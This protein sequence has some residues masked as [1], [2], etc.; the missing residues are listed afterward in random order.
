MPSG[1]CLVGVL[2][3]IELWHV[4]AWPAVCGWDGKDSCRVYLRG[5]GGTGGGRK[6]YAGQTLSTGRD[7]ACVSDKRSRQEGRSLLLNLQAKI[8]RISLWSAKG[9]IAGKK[10]KN[11]LLLV[12]T[13]CCCLL[14]AASPLLCQVLP[15]V[16]CLHAEHWE[17]VM[18]QACQVWES[19]VC[20]WE[21]VG[22]SLRAVTSACAGHVDLDGWNKLPATNWAEG[23]LA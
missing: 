7:T 17:K 22:G 5:F 20:S 14:P 9:H 19:T 15:Y 23:G 4:T 8:S 18:S 13:S 6:I 3:A 16:I 2:C 1:V 12:H 10:E 11:E 21:P